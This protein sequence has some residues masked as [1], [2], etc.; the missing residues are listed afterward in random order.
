[1]NLFS[2]YSLQ[3]H[4]KTQDGLSCD[5]CMWSCMTLFSHMNFY[6]NITILLDY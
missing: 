3:L 6:Q 5:V 4:R 1:M 2:F